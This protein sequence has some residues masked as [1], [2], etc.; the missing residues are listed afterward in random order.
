[1]ADILDYMGA[2]D[3]DPLGLGDYADDVMAAF[4]PDATEGL[5]ETGAVPKTA[6][7]LVRSTQRLQAAAAGARAARAKALRIKRLAAKGSPIARTATAAAMQHATNLATMTT[8]A[9]MHAHSRADARQRANYAFGIT[10]SAAGG[11]TT[12][13]DIVSIK[14]PIGDQ[15]WRLVS[16]QGSVLEIANFLITKFVPA[17]VD[18]VSYGAAG[19]SYATTSPITGFPAYMWAVENFGAPNTPGWQLAPWQRPGYA[20]GGSAVVQLQFTNIDAAAAHSLHL[21]VLG[22][23]SPCRTDHGIK[24]KGMTTT[25]SGW[26]GQHGKAFW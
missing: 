17:D 26:Q 3:G 24:F 21:L 6:L 9:R 14:S 25:D 16:F 12:P 7:D 15:P 22:Q 2:T 8:L 23:C 18:V 19:V 4:N 20:F 13:T 5:D 1:M 10:L 11:G